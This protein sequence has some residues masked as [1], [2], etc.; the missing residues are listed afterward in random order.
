M[1]CDYEKCLRTE[2]AL[3]ALTK[4]SLKLVETFPKCSQDFNAIENAWAIVKERLDAT[5]PVQLEP[6]ADFV[7]RLAA[8]V[9]WANRH[10][11]EQLQYLST[12]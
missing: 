4:A 5:M 8:A 7:K 10:R 2:E 12:N 11:S 9:K 6:R 3:H 1:V